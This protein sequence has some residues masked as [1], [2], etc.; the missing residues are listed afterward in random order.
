MQ[1]SQNA[2]S[3]QPPH[4]M[5]GESERPKA[6]LRIIDSPIINP[7]GLAK[8][9]VKRRE[10]IVARQPAATSS[11]KFPVKPDYKRMTPSQEADMRYK[12]QGLFDGL[13]NGQ[14]I[15]VSEPSSD[16]SLDAIH[17]VYVGYVKQV[18]ISKKCREWKTYIMVVIFILDYGLCWFFGQMKNAGGLTANQYKLLSSYDPLIAELVEKYCLSEGGGWG[19][20]MNLLWSIGTTVAIFTGAVYFAEKTGIKCDATTLHG[21][22]GQ[23]FAGESGG[24]INKDEMG[25]PSIKPAAEGSGL[26]S[27]LGGGGLGNIV[28]MMSGFFDKKAPSAPPQRTR[29]FQ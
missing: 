22:V 20:E 27:M 21:I 26:L 3:A 24:T 2:I 9:P 10:P 6:S 12:F 17:E 23:L 19:A 16:I 13:R 28:G 7:I 8:V 11:L 29:A 14:T 18:I 1:L 5:V 25:I 4:I 15:S